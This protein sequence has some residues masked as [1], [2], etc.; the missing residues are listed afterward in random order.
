MPATSVR[1]TPP[2]NLS[3]SL[4]IQKYIYIYMHNYLFFTHT[5]KSRMEMNVHTLPLNS[6]TN[7][8]S[9]ESVKLV[10][11]SSIYGK[12]FTPRPLKQLGFPIR[13]SS[14]HLFFKIHSISKGDSTTVKESESVVDPVYVPSPPHR[15]L[16]T[17]H[18][19]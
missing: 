15:Q 8:K 17:P 12:S 19:G 10:Q 6:S 7:L 16:R 4:S 5:F 14:R 3:L 18:S 9:I 2:E 11:S 13:T 1:L